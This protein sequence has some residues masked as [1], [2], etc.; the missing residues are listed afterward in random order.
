MAPDLPRA[1]VIALVAGGVGGVAVGDEDPHHT[2][3]VVGRG[4]GGGRRR[5]KE[6]GGDDF[7]HR[8]FCGLQI[9]QSH[10]FSGER[11]E[12]GSGNGDKT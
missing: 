11:E 12:W 2:R 9:F 4:R 3:R 10:F 7:L 1:A 8:V 5:R 6:F